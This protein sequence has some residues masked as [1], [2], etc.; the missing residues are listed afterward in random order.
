MTK[1]VKVGEMKV[2]VSLPYS[3]EEMHA[4]YDQ[5]IAEIESNGEK[6]SIGEALDQT[7]RS[8]FFADLLGLSIAILEHLGID[9]NEFDKI[10]SE[11]KRQIF[12]KG[13]HSYLASK[14]QEKNGLSEIVAWAMA[15][16]VLANRADRH[17]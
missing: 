1:I 7:R 2:D 9:Y 15:V 16:T 13:A 17:N 3:D 8:F 5:F 14:F 10:P 6:E 12:N 4:A 11:D